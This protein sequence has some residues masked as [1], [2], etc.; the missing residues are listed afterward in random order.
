MY[1]VVGMLLTMWMGNDW[2]DVYSC[3]YVE[4]MNKIV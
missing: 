4:F 3:K 1:E 2:I